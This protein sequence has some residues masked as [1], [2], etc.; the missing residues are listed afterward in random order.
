MRSFGRSNFISRFC[1]FWTLLKKQ[2]L[3]SVWVNIKGKL[4]FLILNFFNKAWLI[5]QR[6][7]LYEHF[8]WHMLNQWSRT[9]RHLIQWFS[10]FNC[11]SLG[12]NLFQTFVAFRLVIQTFVFHTNRIHFLGINMLKVPG[13]MET[14]ISTYVWKS[15]FCNGPFD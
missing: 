13:I 8:P 7:F 3:C 6:C 1:I 11:S 15:L 5:S 12:K 14:G 2:S 4:F 10:T 9:Q